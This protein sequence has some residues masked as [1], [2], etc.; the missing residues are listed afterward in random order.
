MQETIRTDIYKDIKY[1]N[2]KIIIF[3]ETTR[4]TSILIPNTSLIFNFRE[5]NKDY[6]RHKNFKLL[7]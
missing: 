2:W 7:S 3:D 5:L 6:N 4:P 1:Y